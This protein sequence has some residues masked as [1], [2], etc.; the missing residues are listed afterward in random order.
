MANPTKDGVRL[1]T[2]VSNFQWYNFLVYHT[3][4]YVSLLG[5][6]NIM[7]GGLK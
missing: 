5:G 3:V 4:C 6:S 7:L 1:G 2:E